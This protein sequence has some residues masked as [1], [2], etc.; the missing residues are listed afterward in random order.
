MCKR[1]INLLTSALLV[2]SPALVLAK[3]SDFSQNL[4]VKSESQF[5]DGKLKKTV[6]VDNVQIT[7]GTL[8]IRADRLEIEGEQGKGKEI[9]IAT[10]R[11][12][13]YSQ[14]LDDGKVVEAEAFEI[15]Y[16]VANRTI[17]LTGQAKL[18]QN[19]RTMTAESITYDMEKEQFKATGSD[20]GDGRVTT[21]Y[22][23]EPDDSAAKKTDND[24][25]DD[26]NE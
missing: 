4:E 13:Y 12:A 23:M 8:N 6:L 3:Q 9:F 7:Q 11:P 16:E 5:M 18:N 10:G 19:A 14:Q 25:Q 17:S 22:S 24:E 21:I 26:D 20:D 1:L 15:R 2:L